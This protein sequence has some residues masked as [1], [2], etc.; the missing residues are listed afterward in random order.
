L[1]KKFELAFC[2]WINWLKDEKRAS[3]NTIESY[4]RDIKKWRMFSKEVVSPKRSDFREFMAKLIDKGNSRSSVARCVSSLKSFYGYSQK[5]GYLSAPDLDLIK[6]PRLQTPLPRAISNDDALSILDS[7]GYG[8]PDWEAARDRA[9]LLLLYGAGLRISE[10]LSIKRSDCPFKDWLR[11]IGKGGKNRDVP[12]L[13]IITNSIDHYITFL[14]KDFSP[15]DPLFIGRR[16]GPLSP[17]IIQRLMKKVRIDLNLPDYSTP[18]SLRH[19]FATQL[20]AGG[21][22]LRSIQDILGHASLSTTQRYTSV[23]ESGLLKVHRNSHP[24]ENL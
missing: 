1:S 17:R 14:P 7:I 3:E 5:Q 19:T 8:R 2:D 6:T 20:L 4:K 22:D 18:H 23:D 24:R 15:H 21:G 9:I 10:A 11:V 13:P 16:G 12:I